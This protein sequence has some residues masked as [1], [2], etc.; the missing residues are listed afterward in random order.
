[1]RPMIIYQGGEPIYVS[2]NRLSIGGQYEFG[3]KTFDT[4]E[5]KLNKGDKLYMYT[6]GYA[7][8]FGGPYGKKFK[9]SNLKKLLQDIHEKPMD[10]QYNHI[11]DSFEL[12]KGDM[13]QVDYLLIIGIEI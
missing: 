10:E 1:M 2:G 11:K 9:T 12:W 7:D 6:D 3:E 4:H 13:S 5:H 8:Q